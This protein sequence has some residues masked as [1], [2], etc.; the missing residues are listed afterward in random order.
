QALAVV[1]TNHG[2]TLTA[3]GPVAAG[4]ILA[5]RERGAIRLGAGQDVVHVRGVAAAV[6]RLALLGQ[7]RLLVEVVRAVQL[8]HVLRDHDPLGVLPRAGADPVAGVDGARALGA[9][10]GVPGLASRAGRL[11]QLL[12]VVIRSRGA[13]EITALAGARARDE[14]RHSGLLG[15]HDGSP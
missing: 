14:E 10:V 4:S 13:A 2:R 11:C 15:M 1:M 9:Q 8:A 7:R 12:T 5:G 3:L 6:D